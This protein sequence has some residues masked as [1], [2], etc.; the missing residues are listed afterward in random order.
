M[1][2]NE[3]FDELNEIIEKPPL[4]MSK[5]FQKLFKEPNQE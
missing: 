5:R 1:K 3:M 2:K 4:E